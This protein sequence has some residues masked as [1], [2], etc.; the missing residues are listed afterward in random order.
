MQQVERALVTLLAL[1]IAFYDLVLALLEVLDRWFHVQL[2]PLHL[3]PEGETVILLFAFLLIGL[4]I[5]RLLAG[6]LRTVLLLVV[7]ALAADILLPAL[8]R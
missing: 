1:A 3:P 5:A 6:L 4:A 7:V 8:Q 2:R